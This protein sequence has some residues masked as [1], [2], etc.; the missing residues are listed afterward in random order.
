MYTAVLSRALVASVSKKQEN[1]HLLQSSYTSMRLFARGKC[2][3][4]PEIIFM[5]HP[6]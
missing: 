4:V 1:G 3:G 6:L 2:F 5:V